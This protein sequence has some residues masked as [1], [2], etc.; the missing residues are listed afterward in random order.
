MNKISCFKIVY[1]TTMLVAF[2]LSSTVDIFAEESNA[3]EKVLVRVRAIKA[4]ELLDSTGLLDSA[5]REPRAQSPKLVI[6]SRL[7]DI[8]NKLK[9]LH[10]RNYQLVS[11][12]EVTIPLK[13]RETI[14]L[15][16][17][18]VLT[19]RPLFVDE[20]R[21]AIWLKWTDRTGNQVLLDTRMHIGFKESMLAGTDS[22]EG[23][24]IILAVE[25]RPE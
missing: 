1:A 4:S 5:G 11:N 2:V 25:A 17:Q 20:D 7:H 24:G 23:K 15:T 22:N 16:E 6:D 13:K 3:Y 9:Q 21:V 19:L 10:F 12:E 18:T 14:N 8:E